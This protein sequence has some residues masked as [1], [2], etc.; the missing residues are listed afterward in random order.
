MTATF[1]VK[2][3]QSLQ[4]TFRAGRWFSKILHNIWGWNAK[5]L[6]FSY[7]G[8][9]VVWKRPKTTLHNIKMVPRSDD[10]MKCLFPLDAYRMRAII[11]RGLYILNPLFGGQKRFFKEVFSQKK[12]A[13]MYG[14]YSN[15][16]SN[17]ERVM[18]AC[19]GVRYVLQSPE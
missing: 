14:Q 3:A 7:R 10:D 8:R 11:I 6:T 4:F 13:L 19:T 1:G 9:W 17:Q 16:V 15:A 18:M 2:C 5:I 12:F